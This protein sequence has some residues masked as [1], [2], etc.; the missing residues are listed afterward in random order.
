MVSPFYTAFP[1]PPFST[2]RHTLFWSISHQRFTVLER[3]NRLTVYVQHSDLLQDRSPKFHLSMCRDVLCGLD[4][5]LCN[6]DQG[7]PGR[8]IWWLVV[9]ISISSNSGLQCKRSLSAEREGLPHDLSPL[10]HPS[11][12]PDW[13]PMARPCLHN[14]DIDNCIRTA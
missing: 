13:L 8:D 11:P 7:W 9:G 1:E 3:T 12:L 6:N 5:G 4:T 14:V 2:S 10:C